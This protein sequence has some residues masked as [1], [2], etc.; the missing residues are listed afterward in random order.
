[1][2]LIWVARARQGQSG[3][4]TAN[5]EDEGAS[6]A[7]EQLSTGGGGGGVKTEIRENGKWNTCYLK[8]MA[9]IEACVSMGRVG[10]PNLAGGQITPLR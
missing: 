3:E 7:G 6:R 1:M 5:S 8:G 9:M 10:P 4:R 2:I